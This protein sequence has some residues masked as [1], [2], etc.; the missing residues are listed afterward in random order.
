MK[1]YYYTICSS[2]SLYKGLVLYETMKENDLDFKFYLVCLDDISVDLV[3]RLNPIDMIPIRASEIR[4]CIENTTLTAAMPEKG[5]SLKDKADTALFLFQKYPEL[6][7]LLW[8]DCQAGLI[9]DIGM[10]YK[11]WGN[12]SILVLKEQKDDEMSCSGILMGFQNDKAGIECL[13]LIT[14]AND[15][16]FSELVELIENLQVIDKTSIVLTP[17]SFEKGQS[18]AELEKNR[19]FYKGH[20]IPLY[21][22]D[23]LKYYDGEFFDLCSSC[24]TIDFKALETIYLPYVKK[25]KQAAARINAIIPG[26][27]KKLPREQHL[28]NNYFNYDFNIKYGS[29]QAAAAPLCNLCTFCGKEDLIQLLVMHQ[30]L[31]RHNSNFYL[32]I[33]CTDKEVYETLEEINLAELILLSYENV[34]P[35]EVACRKNNNQ[36]KGFLLQYILKCNYA[37]DNLLYIDCN[38]YF[39]ENPLAIFR[40]MKNGSI[41]LFQEMD[42]GDICSN[43][44]IIAFKRDD[45]AF[46][47][48]DR[49]K[50]V[51]EEGT[52]VNWLKGRKDVRIFHGANLKVSWTDKKIAK[53]IFYKKRLYTS[54]DSLIAIQ[55]KLPENRE[56]DFN[57]YAQDILH[58]SSNQ[59]RAVYLPYLK[60]MKNCLKSMERLMPGH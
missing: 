2:A 32:W 30:S 47:C 41:F 5:Y 1:H 43:L 42:E 45:N 31:K 25:C 59:K 55:M 33:C 11:Y 29:K 4:K 53:V 28:L 39:V 8:L 17:E 50:T 36:M 13:N 19:V 15:V 6:D 51:S 58:T 35:E 54:K 21:Y 12:A 40:S 49:W 60:A 22:Y 57:R 14:T 3:K 48:L 37:V 27:Y 23:A 38:H 18:M 7:H 52:L 10:V 46:L 20:Q 56:Y 44:P 34:F 16:P 24:K 9:S 26:F